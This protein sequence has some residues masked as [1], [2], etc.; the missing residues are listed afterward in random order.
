MS[1]QVGPRPMPPA[2]V[3]WPPVSALIFGIGALV[4]AALAW[5]LT[6]LVTGVVVIAGA[7]ACAAVLRSG[8]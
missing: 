4:S 2:P 8:H 7:L 6:L 5:S 1:S 3:P